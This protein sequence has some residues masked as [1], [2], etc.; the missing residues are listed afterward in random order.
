MDICMT[1]AA[2]PVVIKHSIARPVD[3]SEGIAL[4]DQARAH[5]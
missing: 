3:V 2:P 1:S 5:I 4:L